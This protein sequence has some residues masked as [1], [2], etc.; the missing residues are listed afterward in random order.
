MRTITRISTLAFLLTAALLGAAA[1]P[2][3]ASAQGDSTYPSIVIC[4]AGVGCFHS[5]QSGQFTSAEMEHTLGE[6]NP[7]DSDTIVCTGADGCQWSVPDPNDLDLLYGGDGEADGEK[8]D[9]PADDGTESADSVFPVRDLPDE[10]MIPVEGN[11][12]SFHNAGAMVCSTGM[13][14]DVPAGDARSGNLVVADNGGQLTLE[15]FDPETGTQTMTRL[16]NGVYHAAMVFEQDGQQMDLTFDLVFAAQTLGFGVIKGYITAQGFECE[17]TRTFWTVSDA[18]L[19][20]EQMN[21]EDDT[22]EVVPDEDLDA[23]DAE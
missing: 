21:Q 18:I 5:E 12:T 7:G 20:L 11:W 17:I 3:P 4:S 15:D 19:E 14:I 13:R 23:L 1:R 9:P 8:A 22:Q 10:P 2:G 16:Q 6:E